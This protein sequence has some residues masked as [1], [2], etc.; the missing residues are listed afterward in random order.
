MAEERTQRRLAAIMAAD[1]VGYSRLMGEDETGTLTALKQ[2]RA[3]LIDPTIAEHRGRIVKLMGDG[4]LVEFGS[5]VDAV[6]CAVSIQRGMVERNVDTPD[7]KLITFRIGV[8]LGDIILD[9]DDIY[10][11]GVNVAARL[12]GLAEPD[13]ICISGTVFDQVKDKLEVSFDD[14]GPREVKNIAEPVR[15]YR[16]TVTRASVTQSTAQLPLPDKPSIAVLPFDNMSGD[17][18]Q[19]FFSDGIS[20]DLITDLSKLQNLFV[21]S[22]NN[23]FAFK[24]QKIDI[25]DV[26]RKLGV[27][28]VLEGSVRKAGNRVR[29]NAQLIEAT[30]GGHV[31][32]DRYDGALDDIFTLQ[33]E[34]TEKIVAALQVSLTSHEAVQPRQHVTDN[35]EAYE[36]YLRGRAELLRLDPQGTLAALHSLTKAIDIDPEFAAAYAFRSGVIQHGWT[37]GFPGFDV[38]FDQLLGDAERAVE[39]DDSLAV[40]HARL[41][42]AL[43]FNKRYDE[44]AASFERAILLGPHD[45]ETHLWFTEALNYAG[46][47][48]KGAEMGARSLELEPTPDGVYYFCTGHSHYLLRNYD[49]AIDLF[50]AAIARV[51]GFPLPYLLYGVVCFEQGRLTDAAEQFGRL[52]KALPPDFL[53]VVLSR[54]PYREEE[55]RRRI[56]NALKQVGEPS[57]KS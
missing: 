25:G 4:M 47:P 55:P 2:H 33:D 24:G 23:A 8:N 14:L 1:V 7:N 6:E 22:R 56:R 57:K 30:T 50:E 42:W 17:P 31:W 19:E 48:G 41:G 37:F 40:A 21:V 36:Y 43:T 3:A 18:E 54:L 9:D 10:G 13:G 44:A 29:I 38:N 45:A 12:E 15:A 16:V 52:Y 51:P 49:R 34:I 28:H 11:D 35:V 39:L 53:D 5:V 32:A 20:E 26:G 27:A 46:E